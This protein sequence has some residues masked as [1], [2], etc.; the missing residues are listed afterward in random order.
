MKVVITGG[1]GFIGSHL[2][3]KWI[4]LGHDVHLVDCLH[5]YYSPKRKKQHL[6]ELTKIGP[7]SF[8]HLNLLDQVETE[9]LIIKLQPEVVVHLAALPGV[10][11][12]IEQP[13][14]YVDYDIKATIHVLEGSRKANVEKVIFASSSS[15]YGELGCS[16]GVSEEKANGNVLS[17]YAA[18]KYSAESFC[19]VY[20]N[21]Y[22]MDIKILR[23]FTV[24]GPW[25]RPDMAIAHFIG[26]LLKGE[27]LPVFGIENS[28]D[29]T[30][31][32]DIIEGIDLTVHSRT[33]HFIFNIGNGKPKS[34]SE[35]LSELRKHFKALEVELMSR[36]AGDVYATWADISIAER[37]LG[38]Y[39]RVSFSEGIS[40]TVE[41][42]KNYEEWT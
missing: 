27:R 34:M 4:Q 9:K 11:Y 8:Y 40:R 38:Y 30:Y 13:L 39:P 23:F 12:S 31:I 7:F 16:G 37:E 36:R 10:A 26:K 25:G 29:Y 42:A 2:A 20:R 6:E 35:L 3:K 28:R 1:A 32:D 21:L 24:Y 41:W 5:P 15:V 18:S 19:H 33:K 17:P 14:K 22:D